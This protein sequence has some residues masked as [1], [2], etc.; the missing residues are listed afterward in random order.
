MRIQV[1]LFSP[2][3]FSGVVLVLLYEYVSGVPPM[4]KGYSMVHWCA[5][6]ETE[7]FLD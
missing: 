7:H 4:I 6:E 5:L 3:S 2:F 1:D